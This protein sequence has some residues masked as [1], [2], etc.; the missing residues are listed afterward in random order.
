MADEEDMADNRKRLFEL[1]RAL[2]ASAH[3][4]PHDI[5]EVLT[6]ELQDD[7]PAET[8]LRIAC[9]A[10]SHFSADELGSILEEELD[11]NVAV[12]AQLRPVLRN[13][14]SGVSSPAKSDQQPVIPAAQFSAPAHP[15]A[16]ESES[17]GCQPLGMTMA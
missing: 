14:L 3:L 11:R 7:F 12:D 9:R 15:E 8:M 5:A 16:S 1:R 10:C 4:S 6:E 2:R 13:R 17:S